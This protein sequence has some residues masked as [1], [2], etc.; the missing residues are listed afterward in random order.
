[1]AN[2]SDAFGTALIT[3]K[4]KESLV[5]ILWCHLKSEH[6]ATYDTT[7]SD[8]NGYNEIDLKTYVD[9]YAT[10]SK[11][12]SEYYQ[13]QLNF[14]AT[15]RW[16]FNNNTKWFFEWLTDSSRIT[17]K[18]PECQSMIEKLKHE[19]I[20]VKFE[21]TDA[22]SGC[23][24]ISEEETQITWNPDKQKQTQLSNDVSSSTSYNASNL[25]DAEMYDKGEI[26]DIEFIRHNFNYTLEQLKQYTTHNDDFST[27]CE[28]ILANPDGFKSYIQNSDFDNYGVYYEI[29]EL[30]TEV[31]QLTSTTTF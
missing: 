12:E 6:D 26:W 17:S 10:P 27:I 13:I 4:S 1:M 20:T 21:Y 5:F 25:I 3:A 29:D 28:N 23:D 19:R 9:K 15:G 30:F 8:I 16:S 24:F 18:H 22:E 14:T 11:T 2:L 31:L 7:F